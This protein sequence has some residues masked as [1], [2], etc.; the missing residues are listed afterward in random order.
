MVKKEEVLKYLKDR[1]EKSNDSW[2]DEF[3]K[4]NDISSVVK[5]RLF[6]RTMIE[7]YE[8]LPVDKL[9]NRFMFRMRVILSNGNRSDKDRTFTVEN[10]FTTGIDK[11][12]VYDTF[13]EM[14][15]RLINT[16]LKE[17]P[18]EMSF[19]MGIKDVCF[20]EFASSTR[21]ELL[22]HEFDLKVDDSTVNELCD[23][24]ASKTKED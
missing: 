23:L 14:S 20:I 11:I 18:Y 5:F 19:E 10:P 1:Y 2:K 9:S 13:K 15:L 6:M 21:G 16:K 7:L 24:S 3:D 8:K 22:T 17:E 12:V 4:I